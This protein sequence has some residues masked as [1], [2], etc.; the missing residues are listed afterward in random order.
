MCDAAEP[1]SQAR[2]PEQNLMEVTRAGAALAYTGL[3]SGDY[4]V[5]GIRHFA[6]FRK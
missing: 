4:R 1:A 5:T 2:W 3:L 6:V